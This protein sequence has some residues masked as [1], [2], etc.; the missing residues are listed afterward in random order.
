MSSFPPAVLRE[1][2]DE[3]ADKVPFATVGE[4][5]WQWYSKKWL[6]RDRAYLK[7]QEQHFLP[8]IV[9]MLLTGHWKEDDAW[10]NYHTREE[11]MAALARVRAM[12]ETSIRTQLA[13]ANPPADDAYAI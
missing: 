7:R 5:V 3:A 4:V 8:P 10:K 2:L 13:D 11:A 6:F 9:Y 1:A 12:L